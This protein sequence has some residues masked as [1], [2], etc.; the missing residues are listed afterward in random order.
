MLREGLKGRVHRP[1]ATHQSNQRQRV[2]QS[3][4]GGIPY[5]EVVEIGCAVVLRLWK[6]ARI[7]KQWNPGQREHES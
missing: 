6:V 2:I 4:L 1:A 3:R 7:G 5:H